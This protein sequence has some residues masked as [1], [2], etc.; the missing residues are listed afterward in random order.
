MLRMRACVRGDRLLLA[1]N[2]AVARPCDELDFAVTFVR[3]LVLHKISECL[4]EVDHSRSQ[5]ISILRHSLW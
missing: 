5:R 3:M 2:V 4:F 1:E